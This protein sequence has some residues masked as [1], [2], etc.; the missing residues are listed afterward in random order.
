[1]G[2]GIPRRCI[3]RVRKRAGCSKP[4]APRSRRSI[5][6]EPRQTSVYQ[7]RHRV[8]QSRDLRRDHRRVA[9]PQNYFICR[10]NTHRSSLRWRELERRGFE[11]VRVAPDSDGRIDPARVLDALDSETAL[12]TLGLANS[13]VG[14]IQDLAPLASALPLDRCVASCRCGPGGRPDSGRCER[15]R[16]RSDDAQRPQARIAVGHRR[17]LRIRD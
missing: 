12:V 17:A 10:S 7:R 16:M 9:T 1:M 15:A 6:A 5:G 13:E 3:A 11:V 2:A 8:E 14:T 4:R